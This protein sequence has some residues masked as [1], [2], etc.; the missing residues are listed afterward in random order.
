MNARRHLRIALAL[1]CALLALS[2][3]QG[4]PASADQPKRGGTL[5]LW[6]PTDL[7]T[8]DPA[9]AYDTASEPV[10][11]LLF[12]GLLE[13]D[14][15]V[16]LVPGQAQDWNISLDGKTY[17]FHLRPGIRFSNG[18]EVEAEDYVYTLQRILSP[19]I[20]SPGQG[21]FTAIAGAQAFV[22]GK[23]TNVTGLSAPDKHTLIIRLQQPLF[24]FRYSLAM[25][26]A[27]VVPRD[28]A[29]RYGKEN[30]QY[31]LVGTG[32]YLLAEWRRGVRWRLA[33]NSYYTGP[34]GYVDA[35][36][37]MVGGDAT[38]ATM[39]L[40]RNELDQVQATPA[41]AVRF[42]RDPKLR[43]WLVP[44]STAN[45]DYIFMN[46]EMPPFDNVLVRRAVNYAIN[47]ARLTRLTGDFAIVAHGIVPP[48]MSWTNASLT[49][50][51]YD[52]DQARAL[53]RQAGFPNG[54]KTKFSFMGDSPTFP[55]LAQDIQQDLSQVGIDA[56]MDP[57]N[58]AVFDESACTRHKLPFGTWGWFQDYPDPSDFLD[59]LFNGRYIVESDCNDVAFYNSTNVNQVLDQ[60][61]AS[62]DSAERT[63]RYRHAEDL[64][65]RDAPWVPLMHEVLPMVYSP[66][67]HGTQ[68][69]PVWLW[70]YE[71]MWLD[72]Q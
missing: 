53:L 58:S 60:A 26:F 1:L 15:G 38:T 24:T 8:L 4:A 21:F 51:D 6:E 61:D 35:V 2:V 46:T 16:N 3:A 48:A 65:M 57:I 20:A 40:E 23:A 72:L 50:Y 69:H 54:F 55:R 47:K 67:V 29:R 11:R 14:D 5:R 30:F 39:M 44:V 63:R 64:I 68:P 56:A 41:D 42:E 9:I 13:Y 45:T 18:R 27:D 25:T 10:V 22:D 12:R 17:T 52:P 66:R 43:S 34:D 31:H 71:W 32:P 70:R 28:I 36:D 49:Q 59:V 33:R 37:I 7:R 19:A 62:L